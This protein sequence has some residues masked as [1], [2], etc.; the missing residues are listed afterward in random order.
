VSDLEE[1]VVGFLFDP[2]QTVVV[3]IE[4]NRPEW[5]KGRLNGPGGHIEPGETPE[6]AMAREFEE[7]VGLVGID[8]MK[9]AV[10][11][12]EGWIVHFFT[13]LD[14]RAVVPNTGTDEQV[15]AV[16]VDDIATSRKVIPN[17]KWLVP[18]ALDSYRDE[19][20]GMAAVV[21]AQK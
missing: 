21:Y 1:M 7:E 8:W 16:L 17:V 18:L 3:L 11:H 14:G 20:P 4:K 9:F 13:A 19:G 12:G 6:Q 5:Q 15:V 10:L 2:T